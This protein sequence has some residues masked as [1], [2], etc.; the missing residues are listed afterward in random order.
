MPIGVAYNTDVEKAMELCIE[1]AN[2]IDRVIDT[3]SPVCQLRGFGDSSVNLEVRFWIGDP[4]NGVKNVES[5]VNLKI[6]K[7]F[8]E[9]NIEIPFPQRDVNLRSVDGTP[10]EIRVKNSAVAS[11]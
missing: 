11:E 2:S 9:H 10:L 6:W 1:A 8:Q 7:L 3:P 4:Q 5:Q